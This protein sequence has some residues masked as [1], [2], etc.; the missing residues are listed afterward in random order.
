MQFN[1]PNAFHLFGTMSIDGRFQS[2]GNLSNN[3]QR[4]KDA[5]GAGPGFEAAKEHCAQRENDKQRLPERAV[6]QRGHEQVEG[7]IRPFL[8]NEIKQIL[9]HVSR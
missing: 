5:K 7:G 9:V 1:Q 6:A 2:T 3:E 8:V 4:Q